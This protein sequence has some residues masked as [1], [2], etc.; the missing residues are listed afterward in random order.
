MSVS[1]SD[2]KALGS[3]LAAINDAIINIYLD[4]AVCL[5]SQSFWGDCYN[6]ALK[7]LTGHLCV[8]STRGGSGGAVTS[9]RVA[10][11][12]ISYSKVESG[13]KDAE[14]NTT[15]YGQ[16]FASL[17]RAQFTAPLCV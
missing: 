3:D 12:S 17:R 5:V 8:L 15:S 14:L 4:I 16:M 13:N 11:L 10:E 1:A 2:V 7:L 9:E 6:N